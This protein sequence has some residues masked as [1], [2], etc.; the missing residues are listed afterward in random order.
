M[1][2]GCFVFGGGCREGYFDAGA[3]K[4]G[5]L[6]EISVGGV[7]AM[8]SLQFAEVFLDADFF[9]K[10]VTAA[11]V[12]FPLLFLHLGIFVRHLVLVLNALRS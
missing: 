1:E 12:N 3:L 2:H 10:L 9:N 6:S 8:E 7:K 5:G 11:A 4:T